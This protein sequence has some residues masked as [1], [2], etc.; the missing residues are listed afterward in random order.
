MLDIKYIRENVEK[1]KE[2]SANRL[3]NVNIDTLLKIDSERRELE[4]TIDSLRTKRNA[5][6]KTKPSAEVIAEMKQAGE[7]ISKL[8]KN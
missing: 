4:S 8:E 7:D 1:I 6:S 3:A 2:N 5:A